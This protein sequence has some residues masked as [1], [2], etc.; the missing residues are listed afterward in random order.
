[1]TEITRYDYEKH[2]MAD[3]FP[4]LSDERFAELKADIQK[5]GQLERIVINSKNQCVDG[6]NR[7]RVCKELRSTPLVISFSDIPNIGGMS[8]AEYIFSRNMLRRHLTERQRAAIAVKLSGALKE[9]AKAQQLSG[10]KK[11]DRKPDLAD[12]PKR[13]TMN[14]RKA[15]AKQANTNENVVR[16]VQQDAKAGSEALD[17]II[18]GNESLVETLKKAQAK[19]PKKTPRKINLLSVARETILTAADAVTD[20]AENKS[21]YPR[22]QSRSWELFDNAV[23]RLQDALE[24]FLEKSEASE[25][26]DPE[27]TDVVE[28]P[29]SQSHE[30]H[31]V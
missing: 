30:S 15:L 2:P 4:P 22:E 21:E 11:G 3:L 19:K 6:W 13:E 7:L 26:T 8:E 10:L 18:A 28:R 23:K 31:A 9:A 5:N 20:L 25:V 24:T 16:E 1:M 14:T 17:G 29:L 12:S 27:F